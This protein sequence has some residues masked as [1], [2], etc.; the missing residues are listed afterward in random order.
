MAWSP[1]SLYVPQYTINGAGASGYVLKAYAANTSTNIPFATD[2][3]GATQATSIA[4]NADGFPEVSG[5]TVIPHIDQTFKLALYPTQ[6]AADA[7]SGA[8][9]TID[10]LQPIENV[11][12]G[13]SV[14]AQ[15]ATYT[16][17]TSDKGKLIYYS[18]AGGVTVNAMAAATAGDGFSFL[19][20]NDTSSTVTFDPNGAEQV[21]G[22]ATFVISAGESAMVICNGTSWRALEWVSKTGTELT[23]PVLSGTVT[24][25]YTLGGTPSVSSGIAFPATQS[26]SADP[27]TLDDYEEGT[28]TPSL[29]GN[30]SYTSQDGTYTKIGRVVFFRGMIVVNSIGTGSTFQFSGLPFNVAHVGAYSVQVTANSVT[31]IVSASADTPSTALSSVRIMSRTAASAGATTNAIFGNST[32]VLFSGFYFI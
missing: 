1:I 8:T 25:T 16:L 2:S 6:A 22:A 4:L 17:L 15:T 11:A 27:N 24:G 10:G 19:I 28:W 18:G 9:W 30:T 29:G 20:E 21:N 31:N 13:N 32:E 23:S 12:F 5:N 14:N 26:P 3:T 7:N